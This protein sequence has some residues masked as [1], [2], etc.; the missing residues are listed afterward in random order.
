MIFH[1]L[2]D[3]LILCCHFQS[4]DGSTHIWDV[5]SGNRE[6]KFTCED[7]INAVKFFPSGEAIAVAGNDGTV[8]F[9]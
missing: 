4:S 8:S 7:S 9:N 6:M 3:T 1:T 2:A 5:R